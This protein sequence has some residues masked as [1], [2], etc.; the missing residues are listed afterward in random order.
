MQ[1]EKEQGPIAVV[2]RRLDEE[3]CG[4][5]AVPPVDDGLHLGHAIDCHPA[6]IVVRPAGVLAE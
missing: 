2:D 5:V 6:G 4:R 1:K 3:S